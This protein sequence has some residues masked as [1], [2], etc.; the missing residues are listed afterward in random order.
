MPGEAQTTAKHLSQAWTHLHTLDVLTLLWVLC[1]TVSPAAALQGS[2]SLV[3]TVTVQ[4]GLPSCTQHNRGSK[5]NEIFVVKSSQTKHSGK[6]EFSP[7]GFMAL[8][9][10]SCLISSRSSTLGFNYNSKQ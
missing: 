7:T 5:L 9:F 3:V 4:P 8:S 10:G 2:L 6:A 1:P